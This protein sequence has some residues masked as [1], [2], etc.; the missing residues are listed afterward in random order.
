MV[1]RA[2]DDSV[3]SALKPRSHLE[4]NICVRGQQQTLCFAH[5]TCFMQR[6]SNVIISF[7]PPHTDNLF[8]RNFILKPAR[9]LQTKN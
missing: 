4:D 1:I 7:W 6:K 8:E 2:L 9:S 3:F 5:A